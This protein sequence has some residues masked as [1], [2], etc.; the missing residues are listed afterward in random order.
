M[1]PTT[2]LRVVIAG[3]GI[4]AI[5]AMMALRDLG[6]HRVTITLLAPDPD[7][8]LKPLRTAEPFVRDHVRRY[9]L[10][11][12]A[13]Q[14]DAEVHVGSL[15]GVDPARHIAHADDGAELSYDALVL[16][17]GAR[18]HPAYE[19]VIT[20]G[21]DA[22]TEV[23]AGLLA[24]LEDHYTRSVAFVVPPGVSWP[25]P[26][27]ELAL[28]TAQQIAGAGIDDARLHVVTPEL[29]PLAIFGGEPSH[30]VADLLDAAGITFHGHTYAEVDHGRIT[31]RPGGEVL[32][33]ARVVALPVLD[34]PAPAGIPA[35]ERG[36]IPVDER[37]RVRGLTDV[38]AA[39]DATNFPIKQGGLACQQADAIAE[40]LAAQA[41]APVQPRPFRP[42]LRGKLLTGRGSRFLHHA[43]AGGAGDA[44]SSDFSLWYPPTKVSGRYL[45]QWLPRLDREAAS[46]P[47]LNIEVRL[48]SAYEAGRH[49]LT[50]D[51]YS[52]VPHH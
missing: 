20:F 38:Y 30:A 52:P 28:M 39:G 31:M 33:G 26:L 49:A 3:G 42:V 2:P 29:T 40:Y 15:A 45:S 10:A 23:L 41:G 27:Y 12:M 36:F 48:G 21:G 11:D 9:A 24:D 7:F 32:E 4:A 18:P 51:P 1:T 44:R 22:R 34:G 19:Q 35:D 5:E 13:A 8:E 17:L 6:E 25:L 14:F 43:L 47:H 46:E 37:G 16:A 50:L